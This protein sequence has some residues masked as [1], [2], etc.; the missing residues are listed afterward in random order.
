MDRGPG[1]PRAP[2]NAFG[3]GDRRAAG[4][5]ALDQDGERDIALRSAEPVPDEP[6][7]RAGGVVLPYSAVPVLP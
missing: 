5:A 3:D 4:L 6:A 7:V 1:Q 2:R